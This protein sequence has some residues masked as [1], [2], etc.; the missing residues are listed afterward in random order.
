MKQYTIYPTPNG[1]SAQSRYYC[2][3]Y[4]IVDSKSLKH[5]IYLVAHNIIKPNGTKYG[6]L[7]EVYN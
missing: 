4:Y 3:K 6:I 1:P 2:G 5:A 7:Q